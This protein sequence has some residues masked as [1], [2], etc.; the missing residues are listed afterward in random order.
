LRKRGS[1]RNRKLPEHQTGKIRKETLPDILKLKHEKYR[2][3]KKC[4]GLVE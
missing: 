1:S 3:K 2:T 4:L